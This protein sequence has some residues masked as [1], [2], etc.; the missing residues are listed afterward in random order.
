MRDSGTGRRPPHSGTG[1]PSPQAVAD[2]FDATRLT[3]ARHLA[4]LTKKEVAEH[5]GVSPP[6]SAS[7][8][9]ASPGP[10]PT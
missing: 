10:G 1:G 9:R 5:L 8:S 7:T 6:R 3:Q 2:A 4:A